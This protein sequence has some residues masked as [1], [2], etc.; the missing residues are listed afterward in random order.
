MSTSTRTYT[1]PDISCDHC[2]HAIET[3]VSQVRGVDSVAVDVNAKTVTI[4]GEPL[5]EPAIIAAIDD[6]GYEVA[7]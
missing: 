6:A 4:S 1:V 2:K 5:D 3:E 7:A